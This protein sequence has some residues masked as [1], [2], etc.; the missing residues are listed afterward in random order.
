MGEKKR[1]GY[2]TQEQQYEAEKRWLEKDPKNKER[3]K[4][5]AMRSNT[6]RFIREFASEEELQ[7]LKILI[8]E[9]E[10]K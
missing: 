2:R 7:E 1:K 9:R 8:A 4:I 10:K 5:N 6:K 3:K